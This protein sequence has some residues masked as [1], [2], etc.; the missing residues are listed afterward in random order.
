M[1]AIRKI[2]DSSLLIDIV[3]L[4]ESFRSKKVEIIILP[5]D[6]R[7]TQQAFTM[8]DLNEMLEGSIT[9]SL[10]GILPNS[11]KSIENYRSERL[12]KF[13]A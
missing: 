8:N 1:E 4:P 2:I 12:S 5:V 10:I 11:G 9:E 13:F 6:E 3:A 7:P